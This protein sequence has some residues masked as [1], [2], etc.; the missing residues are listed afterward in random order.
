MDDDSW[1]AISRVSFAWAKGASQTR[2]GCGIGCF[3]H[4]LG[5][6]QEPDGEADAHNLYKSWACFQSK[7]HAPYEFANFGTAEKACTVFMESS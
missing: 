6:I 2:L 5:K 4:G 7:Y 1:I 3:V